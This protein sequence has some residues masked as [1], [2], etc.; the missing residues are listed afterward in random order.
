MLFAVCLLRFG[1]KVCKGQQ[2]NQHSQRTQYQSCG[3]QIFAFVLLGVLF[4]GLP[5]YK[6]QHSSNQTQEQGKP[7]QLEKEDAHK[8]ANV[9]AE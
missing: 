3:C 9:R 4:D 5:S 8:G 2:G 6:A 7:E 1:S